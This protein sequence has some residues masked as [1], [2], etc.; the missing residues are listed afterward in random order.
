MAGARISFVKR[1][2]S[3]LASWRRLGLPRHRFDPMTPA[4]LISSRD[5]HVRRYARGNDMPIISAVRGPLGHCNIRTA[6]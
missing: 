6:F 2:D 5:A 4:W 3:R 1:A